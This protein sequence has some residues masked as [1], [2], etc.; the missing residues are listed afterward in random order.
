MEIMKWYETSLT[1]QWDNAL[2]N[3]Y[4]CY[5]FSASNFGAL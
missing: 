5:F 1:V 2:D 3:S 4:Y